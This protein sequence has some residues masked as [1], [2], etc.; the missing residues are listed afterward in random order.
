MSLEENVVIFGN[1]KMSNAH[2]DHRELE[3]SSW[4][5]MQSMLR[6]SNAMYFSFSYLYTKEENTGC[7]L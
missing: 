1:H 3:K 4:P 7:L 6:T 2:Q 5:L